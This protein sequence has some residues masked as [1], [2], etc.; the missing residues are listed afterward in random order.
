[1][2]ALAFETVILPTTFSEVIAL[3]IRR[4]DSDSPYL[5]PQIFAGLSYTV[6]AGIMLCLWLVQRKRKQGETQ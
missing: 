5:Y 3:K 1:M 4:P 6:A 2:L